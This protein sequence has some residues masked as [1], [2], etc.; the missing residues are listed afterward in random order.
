MPAQLA[1]MLS[2]GDVW[3]VVALIAAWLILMC[4]KSLAHEMEYATRCHKLKVEVHT[5]RL[6]QI[7]R[8]RDMGMGRKGNRQ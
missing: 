3:F 2:P 7:K 1:F 4:L 6:Q 5:L 8:M